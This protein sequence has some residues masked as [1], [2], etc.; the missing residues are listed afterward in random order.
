MSSTDMVGGWRDVN[1]EGAKMR[2]VLTEPCGAGDKGELG[3]MEGGTRGKWEIG[4]TTEGVEEAELGWGLGFW[5]WT[6]EFAEG[7]EA[8]L[9]GESR[10]GERRAS[11]GIWLERIVGAGRVGE[12]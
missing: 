12:R 2:R 7:A 8:W 9:R 4:L 6:T 10:N 1:R 11:F 3:K 5:K